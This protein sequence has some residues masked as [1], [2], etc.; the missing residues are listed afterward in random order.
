MPGT[1]DI[2]VWDV[3]HGSAIYLKTPGGQHFVVDLGT[4]SYGSQ[5]TFSPLRYLKDR[6]GV[7]RLDGVLIT[8]PHRDHLDDIANFDGLSP[9]ALSRPKHLTADEVRAGNRSE[10]Q[11]IVERYLQVSNRYSDSLASS[12][13]PFEPQNNGGVRFDRFFPRSCSRDNLN[14]HSIVCVVSYARSKILIPGDNESCS[15]DELLAQP[16]FAAAIRETDILVAPHHGRDSGFCAPLFD[17]ITPRLTIISDGRFCDTSATG[18][19][20]DVTQGWTVHKRSGG[21][22]ERKCV[23][24]RNDG[25]VKV[26]FGTTSDEKRFIRVT[27]N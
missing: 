14:N 17:A 25:V 20:D 21:E 3:Q 19:Y 7:A 11:E 24:T 10:D 6:Y 5:G 2:T 8:H 26:A 12:E 27:V 23:T 9:R 1:L 4:G 16:P 22:E 13:N 18:R 15:W